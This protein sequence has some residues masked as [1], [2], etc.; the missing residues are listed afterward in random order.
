MKKFELIAR[1]LEE[2]MQEQTAPGSRNSRDAKGIKLPAVRVLA[3]Q[4]QC[5]ISTILRAYEWLEQRHLVYAVPQSGYYAVPDGGL[6]EE[7]Q[8][9]G[10]L[11]FASAAPDPRVFPYAD[12]RHCVDQAMKQKQAEL[13]LYGTDRGLPSLIE[14]LSEQFTDYQVFAKKEQLFITSG[15]QQALAVLAL[16]PFP[17][18]KQTVLL[19]LPGYHNMPPLLQ[20]LNVPFTGV[21]RTAE[22]LDWDGLERSFREDNIKFFYV[23]PRFHNPL[24]TSLS[25]RDKKRLL[26]LAHKYDVYLVEDDYLADLEND[27]RKDPLWSADT[28][29]RVIYLK[30][31]SKILFP[32][33]RLGVAVL[34]HSLVPLFGAHKRMLDIDTSL[35]S[36]AA[37]EIYIRSGMFA[38]HGKVIRSRYAERM[39]RVHQQ[40]DAFAD[41]TSFGLAPRNGGEHTVLPLPDRMPV[42]VLL[43]RLAKR[44]ILAETTE[45]YYPQAYPPQD[46]MLRLNISNVPSL[47]V[48]EGM[49]I[50]REEIIR[51]TS[52]THRYP[53]A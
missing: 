50:I 27:S 41:L 29:G 39:R 14:L 53:Q 47:R 11:D 37:L 16:M 49:N 32:G 31:Y 51:L 9:E 35:L 30:S 15:V 12:F 21:T 22:G 52:S 4:Y 20:G 7:A 24:G 44:G 6:P 23:M 3:N 5:S 42:R 36:Q 8:W 13:F 43:S 1:S 40:L 38:H 10:P 45:R 48:A 34:P 28:L 2:W 19:E 25:A 46:K 18:G 17:N 26:Q 33:L